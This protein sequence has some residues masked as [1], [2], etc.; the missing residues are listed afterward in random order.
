MVLNEA[1]R[2]VEGMVD[3]GHLDGDLL[4]VMRRNAEEINQIR[5]RAQHEARKKFQ[6]LH[7]ACTSPD[8]DRLG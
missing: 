8:M 6:A 2:V 4:S 7:E 1:L 3:R 5:V